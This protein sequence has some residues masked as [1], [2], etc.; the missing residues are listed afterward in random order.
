MATDDKNEREQYLK[1]LARLKSLRNQ[2]R[3]E[4][5]DAVEDAASLPVHRE[6]A[7]RPDRETEREIGE[8]VTEKAESASEKPQFS[9]EEQEKRRLRRVLDNMRRQEA[10]SRRQAEQQSAEAQEAA[11]EEVEEA[12]EEIPAGRFAE[13]EGVREAHD[14]EEEMAGKTAR[15]PQRQAKESKAATVK[16]KK[17]NP[18]LVLIGLLCAF[19]V[20]WGGKTLLLG[21]KTHETGFYTVAVFG[22]DSRNGNLGKGAL[23]DVNM[24]VS[25]NKETGD[26]R[27]CSIFRD[28]F[29]Q[30]D[31]KGKHHKFNEAYFQGGPEQSLWMMRYNLDIQPDDYVT[32]NWK[33]VVDAVNIMGGVDLEVTPAE[34]KYINSFIT[35]TVKSTGVG[36][37]QLTH[38]GMNHLDG[39]QAVAYARLR[40]MDS[41]YNRTERQR[42]VVSLL[43]DKIH[44]ADAAKRIELVTSV[45]PET[46]TSMGIDDV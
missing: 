36:S 16:R 44:A 23:S 18:L 8:P 30:I 15:R 19:L 25:L 17:R 38:A 26:I 28:T 31:K 12:P 11:E 46:K 45:L 35:E 3:T 43:M 4:K 1:E 20:V 27:I 34:F 22:V 33:A 41:D 5:K 14:E 42:K 29:V 32:F 37:V 21:Q 40:L 9:A 6:T 13:R 10:A 39:V 2:H 7:K 24:L